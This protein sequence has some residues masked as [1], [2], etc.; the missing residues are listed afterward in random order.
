MTMQKRK[1]HNDEIDDDLKSRIVKT[2]QNFK[3]SSTYY[4]PITNVYLFT[5]VSNSL[6]F[7]PNP[8]AILCAA[9]KTNFKRL[10][11]QPQNYKCIVKYV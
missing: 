4:M 9:I 6:I 7:Q 3:N 8:Y 10:Q 11:F 2:N 1:K 5:N